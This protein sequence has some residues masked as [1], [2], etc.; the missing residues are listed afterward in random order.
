MTFLR[1]RARATAKPPGHDPLVEIRGFYIMLRR[2]GPD[3]L[4]AFSWR[5][6]TPMGEAVLTAIAFLQNLESGQRKTF[7]DAPTDFV[8]D[9]LRKMVL[10]ST[11]KATD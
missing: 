1:D 8:P 10:D 6:V 2:F 7:A 9:R 5:S 3:F 4:D 11:G